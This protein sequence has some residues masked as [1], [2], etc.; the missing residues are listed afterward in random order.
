MLEQT[1]NRAALFVLNLLKNYV[2]I[3]SIQDG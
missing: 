2:L 1:C 3:Q